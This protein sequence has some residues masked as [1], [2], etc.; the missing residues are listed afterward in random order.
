[1]ATALDTSESV[2]EK[3]AEPYRL[4]A[5][6]YLQLIA[7]G[8]IPRERPVFLW[9]GSLFEKMANKQQHAIAYSKLARLLFRDVPSDRWY[10][11]T[12]N[13]VEVSGDKVPLPDLAVIRGQPDH[14]PRRPPAASDIELIIEIM[15]TSASKDLG[16]HLRAYAKAEIP[17][18]WVVNLPARR[19][20]VYSDPISE[21]ET[22]AS[23]YRTHESL[24]IG[25]EVVLTLEGVGPIVILV[26]QILPAVGP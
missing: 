13:P 11:S 3:G 21:A 18:Y 16:S 9:D 20:E 14:Y 26:D 22:Q 12:E 24:G 10:V 5:T 1:M 19:V 15:D 25:Q 6:D 23:S 2:A 4:T 17:R 8:I 7:T